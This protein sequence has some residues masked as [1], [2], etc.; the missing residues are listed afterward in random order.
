MPNNQAIVTVDGASSSWFID[1]GA[2]TVFGSMGNATV[3]VRN[4]GLIEAGSVLLGHLSSGTITIGGAGA[5]AGT[6]S[7][8]EIRFGGGTATINFDHSGTTTFAADLVS[9][10][11]GAHFL[12]QIAGTTNLTGS[13]GAFS[14]S[15]N[16]SGGTLA[17]NSAEAIGTG[18]INLNGGTLLATED[19]T[20]TNRIAWGD[21]LSSTIAAATGRTLTL[22]MPSSYHGANAQIRFGETGHEGTIVVSSQGEATYYLDGFDTFIDAGTVKVGSQFASAVLFDH[23]SFHS[24]SVTIAAGATFDAN[25]FD[26][27]IGDLQGSGFVVNTGATN[28]TLGLNNR[29]DT[30]FSGVIGDG[31]SGGT[32]GIEKIGAGTLTLRSRH[33][34]TGDT[35]VLAG[36]LAVE[37]Y[38]QTPSLT[39]S[40]AA[41]LRAGAGA[42]GNNVLI[43]LNDTSNMTL[44][45][46]GGTTSI[47]GLAG[48]SGSTVDLGS[49]VL[50]FSGSP[51]DSSARYDGIIAGSADG[52]VFIN[53]G[54]AQQTFGGAN[55][56]LGQTL[57]HYGTLVAANEMALGSAAGGTEIRIGGRL[58]LTDDIN[59]IAEPVTM[60][61]GGINFNLLASI[62]SL[63]GDN[64]FGGPITLMDN[65]GLR[66]E[67]GA[68]LLVNGTVDTHGN[69]LS[70]FGAGS[71]TAAGTIF[72]DGEVH[73]TGNGVARLA[74]TNTYTGQT[75]VERGTLVLEN[76]AA[77]A[78]T[79]AV[80]VQNFGHLQIAD[81]ETIGSLSGNGIVELNAGLT[82]GANDGD[83]TFS[84]TFMGTNSLTKTGTGVFTVTGNNGNF[85]GNTTVNEGTLAVEGTLGAA[86]TSL[87]VA[88]GGTLTGSGRIGGDVSVSGVIAAGSSP[89]T[90][91]I[92]GDLTLDAGSLSEFELGTPGTVGG[93]DAVAGNDL[94]RVGGDLTLAGSLHVGTPSAGPLARGYYTIFEVAGTTSGAFTTVMHPIGGAHVTPANVY[95]TNG[96]AAGNEVNLL[97]G[98]TER[99]QFWDGGNASANGTV[100][101]GAGTWSDDTTNWTTA[102]GAI[103][104]RWRGQFG[105]FDGAGGGAITVDG[106]K[107]V[108]GLQFKENGYILSGDDI[109]L[110]GDPLAAGDTT[111]SFINVDGGVSS[112]IGS[113]LIDDAGGSYMLDKIGTGRLILSG[114]NTY[115]GGTRVSAG[116]LT[117]NGSLAGGTVEVLSVGTLSGTGDIAGHV[118]VDGGTLRGV[119][120]Q[121]LTMDD[122]DLMA[123]SRVDVTLGGPSTAALFDVRNDL[124]LD[125]TLNVASAGGF[126]SGVYRLFDYGGTLTNNGLD[127][128]SVPAGFDTDDYVIQTAVA[129]Q[130]NLVALDGLVL[131][132]WDGG[133]TA[134]HDNGDVDGGSGTW[135]AGDTNW[136]NADGT[137]NGPYQPNPTFAVFQGTGGTVT[138]DDTGGAIGVTG[139]Q[140][141]SDGYILDGDAIELTGPGGETVIRVGDGAIDDDTKVARI[142]SELTGSSRLV[143]LGNGILRLEGVNTYDGG[144]EVAA[145]RIVVGSDAALG[146]ASGALVF[147]GGHLEA[148]DSFTMNRAVSLDADAGFEV[149]ASETLEVAGTITGTGDLYVRG[150]GTLSLT[151]DNAY[152]NTF[153]AEGTLHGDAG[154]ISGRLA[155]AGN[156][157]F[158]QATDGTFAGDVVAFGGTS[159]TMDKQGA[160]ALTLAGT[161]ELDWTITDGTLISATDRFMGN[162]DI[163]GAGTFTFSQTAD[164]TYAGALSGTGDFVVTGGGA[165]NLT[166]SNAGFA[167]N[168]DVTGSTLAVN[169][170][171]GGSAMIGADGRLQG[172]GTIGSGAGSVVTLGAGSTL[173]PGNSIGTLNVSGDLTFLAGSVYEVEVAP[174]GTQSDLVAVTGTATLA[175]GVAHI[176]LTGDYAL[177][178]TYTIVTAGVG[179][180]G[181]FDTV[182]SD[183]VFLDPTLA[184]GTNDVTLTLTRNDID[185]ST[186]GQTPNQRAAA[187]GL[188][189]LD[190]SNDAYRAVAGLDAAT[191][192][193]AFDQLSGEGHASVMTGMVEDGRI[194]RDA[195][196]D[197]MR[198][199]TGAAGTGPDTT[200]GRAVWADAFGSWGTTHGDG[201]AATMRR[202]S[203]GVLVGADAVWND[204][205]QLGF[206]TG[207]GQAE[208]NVANRNFSATTT[209]YHVGVYGGGQ[210]GNLSVRGGVSY[211]WHDIDATRTASFTGFSDTLASSYT[212][213]VLQAFGEIAYGFE[214]GVARFEPFASVAHVRL[215]QNGFTETGGDAS[216]TGARATSQATYATIGLRADTDLSMGDVVGN[217]H[218]SVGWQQGFGGTAIQT[219]TFAGSSPFSVAGAPGLGGSLLLELGVDFDLSDRTSIGVSYNGQIGMQ[220]QEHGL[221]ASLNFRF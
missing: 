145:G 111:I 186:V 46:L 69:R 2:S 54:G 86:G 144:T 146:A 189:T 217:L 66:A 47:G 165:V 125:G 205:W 162:V 140:F 16:I 115:S 113:N 31:A 177:D 163:G 134:N 154:S 123:G 114:T 79:G 9:V 14:G 220:T 10:V 75:D 68:T 23:S 191:A 178:Q 105:V 25:G 95:V 17:I 200:T 110:A 176:G 206:L 171:L 166:G 209:N 133:N 167:G 89:G 52:T 90:L 138:V 132:F 185:F 12:N 37:G 4:G 6:F 127:I 213:G 203:A 157:V 22:N 149:A 72:G 169:G 62:S 28:V 94:I 1:P 43:T 139:M 150:D 51:R 36:T 81:A 24:T 59:I 80:Q 91:D 193:D 219:M 152:G 78:D 120:G 103:N 74:G 33:S 211:S 204:M 215:T 53:H 218:G 93:D 216:L 199:N 40:N 126:G 87:T 196:T 164:G 174:G 41:R 8:D 70:L 32:L 55:T 64:T 48:T 197:R 18:T 179:V 7:A 83:S 26:T 210:F 71:V 195:A 107:S 20:L 35:T 104:D 49:A 181:T 184:Y 76:G 147:S 182:T 84:G 173:A 3:T 158:D 58:S 128:G 96:G 27:D 121:V 98:S 15:V 183:F 11:N 180:T 187:A 175:G 212:A 129:G 108:N 30:I 101:G 13:S 118:L 19:A 100:N 137:I 198:A 143:K 221:N 77:I 60:G 63:S 170:T 208:F 188:D 99:W 44:T 97:V 201:N 136:T 116:E 39:V 73:K 207:A 192:R 85:A 160:G 168:V 153:V 148:D 155:N 106:V 141:A 92:G 194:L 131:S 88:S 142:Q 102:D 38:I 117:V 61:G 202:T 21:N 67:S 45:A 156:V 124:T 5:A 112:E 135:V 57:I 65:A 50:R 159:G 161:S 29:S 122:L 119:A 172:T 109:A 42:F 56:Y 82:T 151:G 190:L 214:T 130:I 34:F